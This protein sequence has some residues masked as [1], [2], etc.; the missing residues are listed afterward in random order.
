MVSFCHFASKADK[1]RST[2]YRHQPALAPLSLAR[3]CNRDLIS[4]LASE[5]FG[6]NDILGR[7]LCVLQVQ[8]KCRS[9]ARGISPA[10][11]LMSLNQKDLPPMLLSCIPFLSFC[12]FS[13]A[14]PKYHFVLPVQQIS[15]GVNLFL[16]KFLKFSQLELVSGLMQ[17]LV[18]LEKYWNLKCNF[19]GTLNSLKMRIF[20]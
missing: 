13:V 9:Q 1:F 10:C 11:L 4:Q 15:Y 12:I 8:S 14:L 7:C 17:F 6:A 16:E 3:S 20:T 5:A 19:K 2:R 18:L